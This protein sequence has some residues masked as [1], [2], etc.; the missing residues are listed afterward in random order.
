MLAAMDSC[1]GVEQRQGLNLNGLA[2]TIR[3]YKQLFRPFK[4]LSALHS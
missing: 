2:A 4:A 3:S 1:F